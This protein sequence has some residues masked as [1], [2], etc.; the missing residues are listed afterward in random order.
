[1]AGRNATT[2]EQGFVLDAT[3]AA[4]HG[5]LH[6]TANGDTIVVLASHDCD[7]VVDPSIEPDCEIIVGRKI[8]ALNGAYTNGKN[9]RCLHLRF[10]GGARE[11]LVELLATAKK[12]IRKETM[13]AMSPV[14]DVK[15]SS[16]EHFTLQSWLSSRYHRPAFSDE[17]DRRL[18][19][20]PAEIHKKIANAIKPTGTDV[21]AVLFDVDDHEIKGPDDPYSLG[22]V[23]VYNVT[24]D[25]AR[26]QRTATAAAS[27]IRSLF[28]QYYFADG[29]W[30]D[31]EL[32]GCSPVSA[33]A[34]SLHQFR[35]LKPWHFDY[36]E[37]VASD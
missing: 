7:L 8:A 26:A 15:L 18:K 23:L 25:P 3:N 19:A 29:R 17:F 14:A 37:I 34:V 5:L 2:W 27:Q 16:D 21:I 4:E 31:I 1:M 20:K 35:S 24:E 36:L 22:I 32:R 10:S 12:T 28:R 13:L 33:D 11:L 6:P 30:K 9:P